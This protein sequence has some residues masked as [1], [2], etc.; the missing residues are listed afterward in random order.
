LR[1]CELSIFTLGIN[2]DDTPISLERTIKQ[3]L[4]ERA[5]SSANRTGNDHVGVRN[6]ARTI[7]IEWIKGEVVTAKRPSKS[8]TN[9]PR[10]CVVRWKSQ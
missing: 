9:E 6:E 2:D 3:H 5:L 7:C 8:S 4:D 1:N 10:T